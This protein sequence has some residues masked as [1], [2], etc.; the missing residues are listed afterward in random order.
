MYNKKS[1]EETLRHFAFKKEQFERALQ[2]TREEVTDDYIK[3]VQQERAATQKSLEELRKNKEIVEQLKEHSI[4]DKISNKIN[5]P[6]KSA[7]KSAGKANDEPVAAAEPVAEPA[8]ETTKD[9]K[10]VMYASIVED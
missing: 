2:M 1:Y 8:A 5:Q 6:D 7:D 4:E 10:K 9:A 3:E